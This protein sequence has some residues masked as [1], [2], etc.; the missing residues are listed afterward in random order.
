MKPTILL[1]A[2][3]LPIAASAQIPAH[4]MT[5]K[6]CD[7]RGRI[8]VTEINKDESVPEPGRSFYWN[9]EVAHYDSG[10]DSCY[11][12]YDRFVSGLGVTLEQIRVDDIDGNRIAGYSGTWTSNGGGRIFHKPSECEVKGSVCKSRSEFDEFLGWFIP[13]FK[14]TAP[15]GRKSWSPQQ[16]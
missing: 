13:A 14:Q 7:Q 2:L 8:Y 3:L 4:T 15:P 16:V 11:V 1:L 6:L 5:D 12:R 9:L 10:T